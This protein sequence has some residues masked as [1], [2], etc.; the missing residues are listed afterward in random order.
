MHVSSELTEEDFLEAS[1]LIGVELRRT[2]YGGVNT[3]ATQDNIVRFCDG[4]SDENPLHRDREYADGSAFGRL[5]APGMFLITV[6]RGIGAPGLPGVQYIAGGTD[7]QFARPI[8][9]NEPLAARVKLVDVQ[10]REGR[11]V[12]R[13]IDQV[14]ETEYFDSQTGEVIGRSLHHVFRVRRRQSEGDSQG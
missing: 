8:L 2:L 3:A 6:D 12:G 10:W 11:Q 14:A 1:K 7:H 9:Q 13:F 4:I 5:V